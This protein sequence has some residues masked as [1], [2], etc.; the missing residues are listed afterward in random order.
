MND[1]EKRAYGRGYNTGSRGAWPL[2]RPPRPP[3]EQI[4]S[5]LD[6]LQKLRDG[7]DGFI[8]TLDED[9]DIN[10]ELGVLVDQA[11]AAMR[12]VGEWL[13]QTEK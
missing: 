11:D 1:A 2:H 9:D 5:L 3:D 12:D 13:V 6:T 7:V 8:A 10:L 4:A